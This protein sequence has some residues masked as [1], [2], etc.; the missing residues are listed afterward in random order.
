MEQFSIFALG[1][2]PAAG[3]DQ[4]RGVQAGGIGTSRALGITNLDDITSAHGNGAKL[5]TNYGP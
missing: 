1:T 2:L 3:E 5:R 4:H